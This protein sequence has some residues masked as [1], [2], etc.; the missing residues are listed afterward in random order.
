ML[1]RMRR[2]FTLF[3][4]AISSYSFEIDH[5]QDLDTSKNQQSIYGHVKVGPFEFLNLLKQKNSVPWYFTVNEGATPCKNDISSIPCSFKAWQFTVI[6][7]PEN[8]ITIDDIPKLIELIDSDTPCA[9]VSSPYSSYISYEAST[10]GN[11]AA[12]L[13][14][15]FRKGRYPSE[16]NSVHYWKADKKEIKKWWKILQKQNLTNQ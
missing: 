4:L 1:K 6:G 8:W 16:L 14:E 3:L 13:I 9:S 12:F 11:E 7:V 5:D 2:I 15:G 10:I